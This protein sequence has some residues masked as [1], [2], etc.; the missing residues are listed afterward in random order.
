MCKKIKMQFY[1]YL[2]ELQRMK[3]NL[4]CIPSFQRQALQAVRFIKD[5]E[6]LQ[7]KVLRDVVKALLASDWESTPP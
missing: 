4:D 7:E 6:K 3:L 2:N 5:D 1:Y